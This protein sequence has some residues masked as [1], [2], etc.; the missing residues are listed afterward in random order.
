MFNK[1]LDLLANDQRQW[2]ISID[3]WIILEFLGVWHDFVVDG[4]CLDCVISCYRVDVL[5]IVR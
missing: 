3:F 5:V 2:D 1:G 4:H